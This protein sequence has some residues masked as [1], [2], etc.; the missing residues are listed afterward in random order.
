MAVVAGDACTVC[1]GRGETSQVV[2]EEARGRAR[3]QGSAQSVQLLPVPS[4]T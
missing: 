1:W 4:E 2:S 3:M